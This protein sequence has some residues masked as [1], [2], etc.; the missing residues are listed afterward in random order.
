MIGEASS[1]HEHSKSFVSNMEYIISLQLQTHCIKTAWVK[2][3]IARLWT[4]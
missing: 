3:R 4:E 1:C 2:G